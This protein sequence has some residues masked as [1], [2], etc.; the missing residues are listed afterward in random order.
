MILD[1]VSYG[2]CTAD[3]AVITGC[4]DTLAVNFN[5]LAEEEDGSCIYDSMLA[6]VEFTVDMNGVDQPS[7]EYAQVTV[8]G[9]WNGWNGWGAELFDADG[10]GIWTGSL[11]IAAGTT[12][13]YVVSVSGEAD[14][15]SGWGPQWGDGCV[16][17]NVVVTAGDA[18][19]VTSSSLTPGCG[20]VLGCVDT[21][22][23]NYD[24]SE[25]LN[26][27]INMET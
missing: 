27:L 9:S 13:E 14:G 24:A 22:A 21:N 2:S 25:Q 1:V 15:Y 16:N 11:E 20:E 26:N 23:S 5:E 4:T 7:A 10:D 19:S 17:G 18:G 8:N 6:T 12:F 3:P